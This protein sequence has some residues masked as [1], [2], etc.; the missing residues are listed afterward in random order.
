MDNG[1][2]NR[3]QSRL[4]V[5]VAYVLSIPVIY[6]LSFGP[7]MAFSFIKSS[8][9]SGPGVD[10]V[11]AHEKSERQLRGLYLPLIRAADA[12]GAERALWKY[13]GLFGI[14][15]DKFLLR[16]RAV[17]MTDRAHKALVGGEIEKARS[18]V[19]RAMEF[20]TVYEVLDRTPEYVLDELQNMPRMTKY[21]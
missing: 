19:N 11:F 6:V 2:G 20:D 1:S 17:A 16:Q 8:K 21:E 3:K 5:A 14:A 15:D 18:F 10:G 7:A 12:V 9:F 13:A 4:G